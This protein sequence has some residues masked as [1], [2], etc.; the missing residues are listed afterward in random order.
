MKLAEIARRI[1]DH[2]REIERSPEH[3]PVS[4][5]GARPYYQAYAWQAGNRVMVKYVAY[6]GTSSIARME[7]EEYLLA[8]DNGYVGRHWDVGSWKE[9]G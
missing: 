3:N 1:S 4:K 2:L 6:Q 9:V 5:Y 8:L 7:A